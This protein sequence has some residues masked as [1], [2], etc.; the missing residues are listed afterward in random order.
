MPL[1]AKGDYHRI[2]GGD[3]NASG[4]DSREP[5]RSEFRRDYARLIHSAA[6][7]RLVGKTQLFPGVESDFF[8]NRLT[9][10]LE[11]AQI[12]K[13]IATKL[14]ATEEFL[15]P[16][17]NGPIDLD[18]M[19]VAGLAHDLGHPPFGH[20]G[21]LAL[22]SCMLGAGGFEG[23]AQTIRLLARVEKKRTSDK[24]AVGVLVNGEDRRN[25][26]DFCMRSLA[27]VLKYDNRI[28]KV[29]PDHA[30]GVVKGYYDSEAELVSHLKGKVLEGANSAGKFKTL[31]CSIMDLADDIA[32]STYD[33]EDAFKANFLSPIDM[34]AD[35]RRI[36][37]V[38]ESINRRRIEKVSEDDVRGALLGV[39]DEAFRDTIFSS[40]SS[41]GPLK[42]E[43][44]LEALARR[45]DASC[46]LAKNG[47]L[48]TD[49]TS[50]IVG[51]HIAGVRL[52]P[53]EKCPPLSRAELDRDT[54]LTVT[55]FKSF[56]YTSLIMS[57][58][59]R[60][61]ELRGKE[62]V[63]E[64]FQRLSE[65]EGH[66]LL[67]EDFQTWFKRLGTEEER[68]RVICDFVSGMTDR[69]A[70]EFYARLTSESPQSIF[71]PF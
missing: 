6:F 52:V 32:Y 46:Q 60:V 68:M 40:G 57:P 48:R 45:Y 15:K 24:N 4:F 34:L 69:Y 18:L 22:D 21:E 31:E 14:N 39:F 37:T 11:V 36:A 44:F 35:E 7:R 64:I 59:L 47:Y 13:S 65:K 19:E 55:V 58:R 66:L 61:A 71:K 2:F 9:H 30:D 38:I 20:N 3:G 43:Q 12:A 33:L 67:P 23:N 63:A 62:I 70:V 16:E 42:Y 49:L 54:D 50:F 41:P 26:L 27:S 10:S 28:P 51:K 5:Y 1:Y 17:N 29:R 53:N 56:A 8:R 25:G